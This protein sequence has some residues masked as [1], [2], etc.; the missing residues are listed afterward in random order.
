MSDNV[1]GVPRLAWR[2]S[3][4]AAA[5][6]L[7]GPLGARFGLTP[8]MTGF[9]VFD[10]GGILGLVA[11]VLGAVGAARNTGAARSAA[12]RGLVIGGLVGGLFLA[13]AFSSRG[14]PRINDITTDTVKPPR[15]V[16]AVDLPAN[17]DRDM[18]YPG[19]AF[20]EQQRDGYPDLAPLDLAM[21]PA[22]A[23]ARARQVAAEMPTWTI[24]REDAEAMA[25]EGYDTSALFRFQDDFIIEVRQGV[26]GSVVHM[27]SKSRDGQGD[28][29]ANAKRIRAFLAK[30]K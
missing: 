6:F 29:G 19:P 18:A 3:L 15:F 14:Y 12:V 8:A 1:S 26:D 10:L 27:R 21:P 24:T 23:Y 22:E 5:A 9:L 17:A 2:L 4:L 28:I 20:A 30:M 25:I 16:A 7:I 13:L 11:F